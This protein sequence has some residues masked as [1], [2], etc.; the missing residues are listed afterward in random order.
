MK[1]KILL[2]FILIYPI[3]LYLNT[4]KG[5]EEIVSK[6]VYVDGNNMIVKKINGKLLIKKQL[7]SNEYEI[8]GAGSYTLYFKDNEVIA[9]K[10]SRFN[11]FRRLLDKRL[12]NIFSKEIYKFSKAIF[13]NEK[14]YLEKDIKIKFRL[15]GLSH[16]LAI[17]GLHFT[18]IY[19]FAQRAMYFLNF[20]IKEIFCLLILTIYAFT[21]GF[22]PS[23]SRAYQML[24]F[25]IL[26]KI[27]YESI[28]TKKAYFLSFAFSFLYNPYQIGEIGFVLSYVASFCT[29]FFEEKNLLLKNL[30]TQL[31]LT[32]FIWIYFKKIYV[33]SF[34]INIVAIPLFT[35]LIYLLV[36]TLI[37]PNF[38]LIKLTEEFFYSLFKILQFFTLEF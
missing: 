35:I 15:L 38:I 29:I 28:S 24:F 7:L 25:L 6:E 23:I 33:F 18:L 13:L 8:K 3:Y 31:I 36:L 34:L 19:T 32:P 17:S 10:E 2:L 12:K 1:V 14:Y 26:A 16:L 20:R 4:Y 37:F 11:I 22:V 5:N 9:I 27:C 21:V 30:Y